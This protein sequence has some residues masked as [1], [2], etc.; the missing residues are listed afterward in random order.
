[1]FHGGF[2]AF[3]VKFRAD[4]TMNSSGSVCLTSLMFNFCGFCFVPV[5]GKFQ[6]YN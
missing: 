3:H 1:V 4:L 2:L 5:V 6:C